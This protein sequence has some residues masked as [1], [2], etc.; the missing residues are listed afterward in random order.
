MINMI[1]MEMQ[2]MNGSLK[3]IN[4]QLVIK[5]MS[6]HVVQRTLVRRSCLMSDVP[7]VTRTSNKTRVH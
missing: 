2:E 4:K 1:A 6:L 7:V 3:C 5:H